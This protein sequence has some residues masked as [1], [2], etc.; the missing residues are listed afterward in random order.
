MGNFSWI[1]STEGNIYSSC[2]D[3]VFCFWDKWNIYD[4]FPLGILFIRLLHQ[5]SGSEERVRQYREKK[6]FI[7]QELY[8]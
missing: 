2:F 5:Q 6:S 4:L 7:F 1:N 8:K 3:Q